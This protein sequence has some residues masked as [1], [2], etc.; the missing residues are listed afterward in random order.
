MSK[1]MVSILMAIAMLIGCTLNFSLCFATETI[2]GWTVNYRGLT[3]NPETDF[4]SYSTTQFYEGNRSLHVKATDT[5]GSKWITITSL[6]SVA[7]GETYAVSFYVYDGMPGGSASNLNGVKFQLGYNDAIKRLNDTEFWTITDTQKTG[8]KK[9]EGNIVADTT[10]CFF[11]LQ[12]ICELYID[13][14]SVSLLGN[15]ENLIEFGDFNALNLRDEYEPKNAMITTRGSGALMI[16]WRNPIST[17]LN[18][19]SIYDVTNRETPVL[20]YDEASI[21]PD[22]ITEHSVVGLTNGNTYVYKLV[23][24]FNNNKN[25]EIILSGIPSDLNSNKSI[26]D[27]WYLRYTITSTQKPYRCPVDMSLDTNVVAQDSSASLRISSNIK[28]FSSN[29]Y[30][31]L[32]QNVSTSSGTT[33]RLAMSIKANNGK[34]SKITTGS[35]YSVNLL[36]TTENI[37]CDWTDKSWDFMPTASGTFFQITF[38][39]AI[40]DLWIDNVSL[41]ELE[42]GNIKGDNLLKDGDFDTIMSNN[43]MVSNVSDVVGVGSDKAA[44]LSWSSTLS[45]DIQKINIYLQDDESLIFRGSVDRTINNITLGQL[46]NNVPHTFVLKAVNSATL[47]SEGVSVSVTPVPDPYRISEFTLYNSLNSSVDNVQAGN[48]TAK[49]NIKNNLIEDG[50]PAEL[51]I[52]LYDGLQLVAVNTSG[53]IEVDKTGEDV[54]A[55]VL[56]ASLIVPSLTEGNYTIKTFLWNSLTNMQVIKPFKEYAETE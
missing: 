17:E 47:E 3:Y 36:S 14:I 7:A 27:N 9:Y 31:A 33:Y 43:I 22:D 4:V 54:P 18:K 11:T 26:G 13:K 19:V 23:Y 10:S 50:I 44:G 35:G 48:M 53:P 12:S 34:Y 55:T 32:R 28:T 56:N 25:T 51:I 1:K 37:T 40:E 8:W 42:N 6:N 20:L 38:E 41:Y 30:A 5:S 45:L 49:I 39:N 52:A 21:V 24:S 16:S 15:S 46:S 2:E 29:Y